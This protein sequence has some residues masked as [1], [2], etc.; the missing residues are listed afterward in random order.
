MDIAGEGT[1]N[2]YQEYSQK[3][4]SNLIKNGNS[5]SEPIGVAETIYKAATDKSKK[6]RYPTGKMK[7]MITIR[8]LLPFGIYKSLVKSIL[9]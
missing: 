7:N 3:V 2:E 9:E 4:L 6:M 1:I 8:K 5:G